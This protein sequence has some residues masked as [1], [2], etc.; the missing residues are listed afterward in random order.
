ML[1]NVEQSLMYIVTDFPITMD[2]VEELI[3]YL[4]RLR[5]LELCAQG[6]IGL[7]NGY[8]WQQLTHRLITFNFFFIIEAELTETILNSFR[9]SFWLNEK[10]WFVAYKGQYLFSVPR[11]V[12]RQASIPFEPLTHSTAPHESLYYDHITHL[13]VPEPCFIHSRRFSQVETLDLKLPIWRYQLLSMIDFNRVKHLTLS[14]TT[15]MTPAIRLL[16]EMPRL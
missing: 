4:P 5:H 15:E 8:R 14:S 13:R 9:S 1:K 3:I 6:Q 12:N 2:N 10:Q 11:F 7:I 16:T